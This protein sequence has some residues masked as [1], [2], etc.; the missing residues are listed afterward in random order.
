MLSLPRFLIL[1][2]ATTLPGIG[3]VDRRVPVEP[4]APPWRAIGRVQTE[5]GARCTGFL[6]APRVVLTAAHCLYRRTT[7]AFVQPG[8]VHFLLGYDQGHYV[9]HARAVIFQTGHDYDPTRPLADLGADWAALTLDTP[10]GTPDR[11]LPLAADLPAPGTKVQLGG[12][13]QDRAEVIDADLDCRVT[14]LGYDGA[15]H[16]MIEHDCSGTRGTSGAPLLVQRKE[17][18]V[19]LGVQVAAVQGQSLGVAVAAVGI[20]LPPA[21]DK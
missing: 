3:A 10:L 13:G 17:G 14:R 18:W 20:K 15:R 4:S 2:A 7:S 11:I 19:A 21:P 1:C 9:G 5:L 8:S 6:V 12:Y 16:L